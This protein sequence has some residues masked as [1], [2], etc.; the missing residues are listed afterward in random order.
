L[1]RGEQC[2]P[3]L[4]GS[5]RL[6]FTSLLAGTER[7]RHS[8]RRP[9]E[10]ETDVSCEL[11]ELG[12]KHLPLDIVQYHISGPD[13]S[14]CFFA[15]RSDPVALGVHAFISNDGIHQPIQFRRTGRLPV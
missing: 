6:L 11:E 5:S 13:E 3:S 14:T 7:L 1:G 10:L 4:A 8:Q 2:S 15:R 9:P 12:V